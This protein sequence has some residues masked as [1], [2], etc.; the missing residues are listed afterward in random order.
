M[1]EPF[2]E[3]TAPA[4]TPFPARHY[5]ACTGCGSF[6]A[7]GDPITMA[8]GGAWCDD[9]TDDCHGRFKDKFIGTTSEEMGF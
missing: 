3:A 6:L 4:S 2:E 1:N 5:G 8:D 9:C 7:P